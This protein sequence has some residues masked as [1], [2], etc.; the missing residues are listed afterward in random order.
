MSRWALTGIAALIA[1]VSIVVAAHADL[2]T[3]T[4][5][6]CLGTKKKDTIV[7][8]TEP[9]EIRARGGADTVIPDA[10]DDVVFGG[11]GNDPTL[12]GDTG[13]DRSLD[14]DDEVHGGPG[15]DSLS[16]AGR[17]DVLRGGPGADRLDA[18]EDLFAG[19]PPIPGTDTVTGGTANDNVQAGDAAVDIINCGPG[20]ADEAFIDE[21]MDTVRNCE[22]VF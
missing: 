4:A 15:D 5:N 17:D 21:G 12:H 18:R 2:V 13:F 14:G 10:D 7:G 9:D 16:G 6:P 3:C 8:T 20:K 11:K 22:R 1:T 19:D